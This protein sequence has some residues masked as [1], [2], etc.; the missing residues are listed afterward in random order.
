MQ[1]FEPLFQELRL[2]KVGPYI[3]ADCVLVDLGCDEEMTLLKR[4]QPKLTKGIGIDIVVEPQQI[5]N[6]EIIQ[7]DITQR[8]PLKSNTADVV[9]MLAV[10]EHLPNPEQVLKEAFRILKPGGIFLVTVPSAHSQP[11]LEMLAKI[12]VVRQEMVDQHHNYFT[13]QQLHHITAAAGFDEIFIES[14]EL[15]CN[16]FMRAT[17]PSKS[18]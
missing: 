13:H 18:S 16:T 5:D 15:G 9:T 7:A 14:W 3:P 17:K 12:N 11:L 8:L 2:W 4:W 6:I 10:L 1:G